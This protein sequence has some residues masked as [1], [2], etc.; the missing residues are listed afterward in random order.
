MDVLKFFK[1]RMRMCDYYGGAPDGCN[2]CPRNNKGCELPAYRDYDYI[3]EYIADVEQW[4]KDHPQRTRLQD[5]LEKYPNA[6]ICESGLPSACCM[7][8]GYCKRCDDPENDCEVCW[9]ML[10]EDDE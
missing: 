3:K 2:A 7:S 10:M 4:S 6:Q 9:N 8:L 1:E 5:F